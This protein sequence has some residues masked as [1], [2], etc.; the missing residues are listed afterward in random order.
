M[1]ASIP[2]TSWTDGAN[3]GILM[4]ADPQPGDSYRQE[5]LEGFAEDEAA[6]LRLNAS[7]SY[8]DFENCLVTKEWTTLERGTVEKKYYVAGVGLV[9]VEEV[10]GGATIRAP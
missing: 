1:V 9:L 3:P 8:G 6:V 10:S 5:F 7:V 2:S 4:L